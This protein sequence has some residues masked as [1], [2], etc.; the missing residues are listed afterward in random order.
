MNVCRASVSSPSAWAKEGCIS[1]LAFF[2]HPSLLRLPH[3]RTNGGAHTSGTHACSLACPAVAFQ[4]RQKEL[5]DVV[6]PGHERFRLQSSQTILMLQGSQ[7]QPWGVLDPHLNFW[8]FCVT[9]RQD[10]VEYTFCESYD[11]QDILC[12]VFYRYSGL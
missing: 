3:P 4:R 12:L 9:N 10:L 11:T 7:K 2:Q 1:K 8:T 6:S 5:Y